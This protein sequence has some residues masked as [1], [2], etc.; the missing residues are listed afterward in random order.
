MKT[1][2]PRSGDKIRKA[3]LCDA[4]EIHALMQPFVA[5]GVLLP[6]GLAYLCE[7]IRDFLVI[8]A[9]DRRIVAAGALH[10]LDEDLAE[11]QSLA[12]LAARQKSGLGRRLVKALLAEAR[13]HRIWKVFALSHA[14]EFFTALG[15]TITDIGCLPRKYMRDCVHCPKLRGCHQV[16][17][18]RDVFEGKTRPAASTP[19]W[20]STSSSQLFPHSGSFVHPRPAAGPAAMALAAGLNLPILR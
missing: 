13:R 12:V 4:G 1:S 18:I 5:Q 10:F 11:L 16:A 2:N 9:G 6:R 15:F 3:R 20:D 17:V 7:N 19:E 8:E 14:P